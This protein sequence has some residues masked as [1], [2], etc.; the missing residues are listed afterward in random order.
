MDELIFASTWLPW[1][2]HKGFARCGS[3]RRICFRMI[4]D[5]TSRFLKAQVAEK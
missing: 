3:G 5:L 2:R 1:V 4:P